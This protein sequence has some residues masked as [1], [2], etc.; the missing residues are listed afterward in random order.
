MSK[1]V[2]NLLSD[3]LKQ[4]WQGVE[5]PA[6]GVADRH[7]RE[8]HSVCGS[9]LRDK[10]IHLMMVKNSMARRAAEGTPLAAAFAST[11]VRWPPCGVARISSARQ[12]RDSA[13]RRQAF[14]PFAPQGGVMEGVR[15]TLRPGPGRSASGPAGKNSSASWSGQILS[16]GANLV[17]QLTSVG[18]AWPA[19]SSKRCEGG[20]EGG[21][22]SRRCRGRTA[23]RRDLDQ[24]CVYDQERNRE[25]RN[26]ISQL[27]VNCRVAGTPTSAHRRAK[28]EKGSN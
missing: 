16:P 20:D 5:M 7:G 11:E 1:Y 2:K 28:S 24:K 14:A 21:R 10:N 8:Q 13:R 25:L 3:D 27:P 15:L 23:A 6:A 17:S 19:K 12:G 22:T 26:H 9:D 4:R 18:G